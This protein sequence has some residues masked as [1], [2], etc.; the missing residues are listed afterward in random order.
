M[1]DSVCVMCFAMCGAVLGQLFWL[2]LEIPYCW[3]FFVD[4]KSLWIDQNNGVSCINFFILSIIFF[5]SSTNHKI[6]KFNS[7]ENF[8]LYSR[9]QREC[10]VGLW[11]MSLQAYLPIPHGYWVR[12]IS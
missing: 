4:L 5:I 8:Q 3:E 2:H 10:R 9:G 6:H 12:M 1:C 11:L 7:H